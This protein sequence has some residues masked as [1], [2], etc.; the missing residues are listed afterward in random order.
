MCRTCH[1]PV[2]EITDL[3][4]EKWRISRQ[5]FPP[6]LLCFRLLFC[7]A[8]CTGLADNC[9]FDLSRISHFILDLFGDFG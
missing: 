3:D 2:L 1:E 8:Y 7:E 9:N 4:V 5:G 6:F